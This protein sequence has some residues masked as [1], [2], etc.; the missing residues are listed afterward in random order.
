MP[1]SDHPVQLSIARSPSQSRLLAFF[2]LIYFAGRYVLAIPALIVLIFVGIAAFVVAWIGQWA[3]LF[4]GRYPE[5]MHGFVVGY[6]RWSTR[7]NA[8]ILGVTD[9]YPPFRLS[10]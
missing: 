1:A 10:P 6:M 8:F 9:K 2:S 5:G 7:V 4:T 3:I